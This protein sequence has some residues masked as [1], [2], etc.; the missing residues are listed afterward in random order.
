MLRRRRS[1]GECVLLPRHPRPGSGALS[2]KPPCPTTAFPR[3]LLLLADRAM[4]VSRD[5]HLSHQSRRQSRGGPA[6]RVHFSF[7][8]CVSTASGCWRRT[9]PCILDTLGLNREL[10]ITERSTCSFTQVSSRVVS[11]SMGFVGL[12]VVALACSR[13]QQIRENLPMSTTT[14]PFSALTGN[15]FPEVHCWPFFTMTCT[16]APIFSFP[17]YK[18]PFNSCRHTTHPSSRA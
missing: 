18:I 10:F 8:R 3:S 4:Y 5:V 12:D 1:W 9:S 13:Q 11:F 7:H 2:S 15:W 14:T 17:R 6:G 16:A